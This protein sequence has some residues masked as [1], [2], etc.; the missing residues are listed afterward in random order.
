MLDSDAPHDSTAVDV[1]GVKAEI[2]NSPYR[3][4]TSLLMEFEGWPSAPPTESYPGNG[5]AA[6]R[7]WPPPDDA[8]CVGMSDPSAA[9]DKSTSGEY[10]RAASAVGTLAHTDLTMSWGWDGA[11]LDAD[12]DALFPGEGICL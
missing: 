5:A 10:S 8:L 2:A 12:A 6:H 3:A 1:A 11:A 4:A 7:E 9:A